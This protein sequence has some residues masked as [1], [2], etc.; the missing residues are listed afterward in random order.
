MYTVKT[1]T[2]KQYD[3]KAYQINTIS[4]NEHEL[5]MEGYTGEGHAGS[6]KLISVSSKPRQSTDPERCT[7]LGVYFEG[8]LATSLHSDGSP[9][10]T[11]MHEVELSNGD[12]AEEPVEDQ[13]VDTKE[14]DTSSL[15]GGRSPEDDQHVSD[16][17]KDMRK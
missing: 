3:C 7:A 11:E 10:G 13:Q 1:N 17:Q 12:T 15:T 14:P 6:R 8:E 4:A 5:V 2:G 16:A 9:V